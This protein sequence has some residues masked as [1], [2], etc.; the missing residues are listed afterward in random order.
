MGLDQCAIDEMRPRVLDPLG[1]D[2]RDVARVNPRRLLQ[3]ARHRP[4]RPVLLQARAGPD[5]ELESPRALVIVAVLRLQADVA[6]EAGEKRTVNALVGRRRRVLANPELGGHLAQLP[7]QVAPFAHADVR[8]EMLAA[9]LEKLSVRLL[10][11]EFLLEELPQIL[12]LHE[13]GGVVA[14]LLV[15][16]VGSLALVLRAVAWILDRKRGGEDDHLGEAIELPRGEQHTC[17]ARVDRQARE[18]LAELAEAAFGLE[19]ADPAT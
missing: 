12:E 2:A 15:R 8:E 17:D 9:H 7:R 3:L 16:A 14:E 1:L 11:R 4:A 19:G 10:V 18:L 5:R 6:E 13:V